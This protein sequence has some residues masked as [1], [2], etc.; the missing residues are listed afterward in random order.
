MQQSQSIDSSRKPILGLVATH[1]TSLPSESPFLVRINGSSIS[2]GGVVIVSEHTVVYKAG[3]T[4]TITLVPF[5]LND[6]LETIDTLWRK[7]LR[8]A[9]EEK[10][11]PLQTMANANEFAQAL[12]AK[13]DI[14]PEVDRTPDGEILFVW[15]NDAGAVLRILIDDKSIYH[16]LKLPSGKRIKGA[17]FW[18]GV[19]PKEIVDCLKHINPTED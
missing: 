6:A 17:E 2:T 16:F 12:A 4:G 18:S 13:T 14:L 7:N 1:G 10:Q 5:R 19:V 8:D 15:D 3:D 11:I 9:P